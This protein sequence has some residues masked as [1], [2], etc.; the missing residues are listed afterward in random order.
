MKPENQEK[1]RKAIIK[2]TFG[3]KSILFEDLIMMTEFIE[4]PK[5]DLMG[6]LAGVSPQPEKIIIYLSPA[7]FQ[8]SIDELVAVLEHEYWHILQGHVWFRL[9]DA[10]KDNI[11]ADIEI[12]QE[13]FINESVIER[14][15]GVTY[16][17]FKLPNKKSRE[18][19]YEN[20]KLPEIKI[21]I[22]VVNLNDK[23]DNNTSNSDSNSNSNSKKS[24][25]QQNNNQQQQNVKPLDDHDLWKDSKTQAAE[26]IYKRIVENILEKVKD[27]GIL[28]GDAVETILAKW[29]KLKSLEQ[30]L[31]KLVGKTLRNSLNRKQTYTRVNRRNILLPGTKNHYGPTVVFAL[32][33]SGSMDKE[34]LEHI[35]GVFKWLSRRT[36]VELIQCDADIHEVTKNIRNKK[37]I[38]IKGRGGTD[39]RPVFK[40]IKE[41]YKD[42]IDLLVYGTD[43]MGDFPKE[44]PKYKVIWVTKDEGSVPFGT[45]LKID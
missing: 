13:P 32:D 16:S 42:K 22:S 27:K 8:K 1:L 39:F 3:I 7:L 20:I 15:G 26:Q 44:A 5:L 23:N 36:N 9:K 31:K 43:L 38:E 21:S 24:K 33:T 30:V 41:K 10:Y 37:V 11:A 35:I 25:Q 19:Y 45:I 2:L 12:N 18:W 6:A 17:K 28:P 14:I 29:K 4:E 34:Y 40:Y